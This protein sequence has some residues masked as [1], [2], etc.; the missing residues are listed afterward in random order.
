MQ[1]NEPKKYDRP[2]SMMC[3]QISLKF[4]KLNVSLLFEQTRNPIYM[5][6]KTNRLAGLDLNIN[7]KQKQ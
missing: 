6:W 7:N 2:M 1:N 3:K 5:E 4:S